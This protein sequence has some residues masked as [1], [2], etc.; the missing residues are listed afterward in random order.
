MQTICLSGCLA[1]AGMSVMNITAIQSR[2]RELKA[3]ADSMDAFMAPDRIIKDKAVVKN[4]GINGD[5]YYPEMFC[6]RSLH[7][8]VCG[9]RSDEQTY[10]S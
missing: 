6:E 3:L 10:Q 2:T 7:C 9:K 4:K 1:I 5:V 8:S